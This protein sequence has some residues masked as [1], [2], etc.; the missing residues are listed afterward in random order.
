VG[1]G[2]FVLRL[3]DFSENVVLPWE[4]QPIHNVFLLIWAE[5]GIFGLGLFLWWMMIIFGK[6]KNP[7]AT[8]L[9][10]SIN[11]NKNEENKGF[12]IVPRGTI[13]EDIILENKKEYL[14]MRII[15][16]HLKGI[17]LGF[18]FIALFDHY[19]WDI[20]QGQVMFWLV[21]GMMVGIKSKI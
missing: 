9:S 20:W 11:Y 13:A 1:A 19:L 4:Y 3:S 7:N 6:N 15:L 8:A 10:D 21:T 16:T 18:L 12:S 17:M 14:S 5:L 2:Q